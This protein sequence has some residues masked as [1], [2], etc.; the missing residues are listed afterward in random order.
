MLYEASWYLDDL[1][2]DI[3]MCGRGN[4]CADFDAVQGWA[5]YQ[6]VDGWSPVADEVGS[7]NPKTWYRIGLA[8]FGDSAILY[9]DGQPLTGTLSLPHD[10]KAAAGID[11][12]KNLLSGP[13]W[14]DDITVRRFTLPEPTTTIA[15]PQAR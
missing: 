11:F 6:A 5:V 14:F 3:M 8:V 7:P 15:T 12:E 2:G 9:K 4:V 13:V 1:D 10:D